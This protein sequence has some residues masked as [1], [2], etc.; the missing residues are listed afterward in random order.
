M[1]PV[2]T[3]RTLSI[4]GVALSASLAVS[5]CGAV[6]SVDTAAEN[7]S[8]SD[9]NSGSDLTD[10]VPEDIRSKGVITVGTDPTYP[11]FE[12][13]DAQ[14]NIVGL[15]PDLLNAIGEKLDID[16]QFTKASFDSIIP[17][18]TSGRYDMAMS[19]MT[20][21][22]ER[23]EQVDFVDYFMG[24]GVIVMKD[25]DEMADKSDDSH[26]CGESVGIQTGTIQADRIEVLNADCKKADDKPIDVHNFASV[27]QA[28]LGM[29][30]GR[31]DYVM[32]NNVNGA[33]M[34]EANKGKFVTINDGVPGK[35]AGMVFDK[36][37]Q[38]LRDAVEAGLQAVIDDGTYADLMAEYGL[39]DGMVDKAMINAG[40]D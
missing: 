10:L 19:A 5:A 34:V 21:T 28:A 37:S 8:P 36:E 12:E 32:T 30:S 31:I 25:G 24:L 35:P 14:E 1:M 13:L 4:V 16:V 15:D 38:E 6:S 9:T 17:G 3:P 40:S 23:Q 22:P 33:N 7:T 20:D 26:L 11:P 27:Q 18:L 39:E 29:T 2:R